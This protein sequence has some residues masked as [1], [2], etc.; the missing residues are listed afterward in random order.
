MPPDPSAAPASDPTP[1][2][3][4]AAVRSASIRCDVCG[5]ETPHRILHVE[6]SGRADGAVR[7][8]A[9]CR[10]CGLTHPFASVPTPTVAVAVIVSDGPRSV[11]SRVTLPVGRRLQVGNALPEHP[12]PLVIHKIEDRRGA[13]VLAARARSIA[14][15]WAV[16]DRGPS[17]RYSLIQGRITRAGRLAVAPGTTFEVGASVGLPIGTATIVGVRARGHTWRRPGDAFPVEEVDRIYTRR[18]VRPPAGS[19]DCTSDRESPRSRASAASTSGRSRSTPG[20]RIARTSP[21]ARTAAS[22]ATT[23]RSSDS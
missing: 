10:T 11:R 4:R 9:R 1:L 12:E 23:H 6:R 7:G 5:A 22:G 18:T 15:I 21:R 16:R 2:D 8:I 14:T 20:A 19:S 3:A 13:P 17:V